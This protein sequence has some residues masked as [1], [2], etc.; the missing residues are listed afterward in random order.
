M[1]QVS[2]VLRR[3]QGRFFHWCPSCK[4]MHPLPD[5][6]AFDGNVEKPTFS[7]SFKHTSVQWADGVD[8]QGIGLG[9]KQDRVCHY[10]ITSG[11]IHFCSD[12]WHGRS[13]VVDMPHLPEAT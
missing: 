5:G 3:G 10:I 2:A 11:R 13:D 6:W 9:E 4:E 12:S 7:P 8:E 1:S